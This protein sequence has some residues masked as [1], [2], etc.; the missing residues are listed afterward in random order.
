MVRKIFI[1]FVQLYKRYARRIPAPI[2]TIREI[3][4]SFTVLENVSQ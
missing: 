1:P 4:V 3:T 2:W